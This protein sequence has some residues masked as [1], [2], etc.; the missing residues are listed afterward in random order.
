MWDI[1]ILSITLSFALVVSFL[2]YKQLRPV[3]LRVLVWAMILWLSVEVIGHAYYEVAKKSNHFI[4]NL[5]ILP[6]YL[7]YFFIFYSSFLNP[8]LKKVTIYASIGFIFI[9]I[10]NL[11]IL[12][13]F[14][15]YSYF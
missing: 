10:Y 14:Y 1:A 3:Q 4:Y 6:E 7:I 15:S 2:Y 11:F 9:Y 12:N 13:H 8:L 5:Y